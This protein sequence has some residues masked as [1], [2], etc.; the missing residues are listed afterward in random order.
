[1][2]IA[3]GNFRSYLFMINS[4]DQRV[5]H[6]NQEQIVQQQMAVHQ[7]ASSLH[8]Q[9]G[10]SSHNKHLARVSAGILSGGCVAPHNQSGFQ[11]QLL[12]VILHHRN[13]LL[14]RSVLGSAQQWTWSR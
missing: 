2:D 13:V 1:M 10:S 12:G 6:A 14:G 7:L 4:V 8:D 9:L 11:H 5:L 3:L